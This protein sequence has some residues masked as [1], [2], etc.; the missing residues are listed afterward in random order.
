MLPRLR[1]ALMMLGP[2]RRRRRLLGRLAR[3]RSVVRRHAERSLERP[4]LLLRIVERLVELRHLGVDLVLRLHRLR[5]AG[6][7]Q[8]VVV[9][10]VLLAHR[11]AGVRQP[12]RRQDVRVDLRLL[13]ASVWRGGWWRRRVVRA[14]S[15]VLAA[16][17]VARRRSLRL[18]EIGLFRFASIWPMFWAPCACATPCWIPC[19]EPPK[20]LLEFAAFACWFCDSAFACCIPG[21]VALITS[22]VNGFI[23]GSRF[24]FEI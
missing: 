18:S 3:G 12:L 2:I 1:A 17:D 22:L 19:R 10:D 13:R 21:R 16:I 7:R 5:R 23:Y 11:I 24:V 8:H 6:G 4:E 9:G 14:C 20:A 15:E